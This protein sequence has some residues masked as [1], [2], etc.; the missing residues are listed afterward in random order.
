[1]QRFPRATQKFL[2][3]M[4]KYVWAATLFSGFSANDT[5]HGAYEDVQLLV[6]CSLRFEQLLI[7]RIVTLAHLP[8]VGI[9][10]IA[11]FSDGVQAGARHD[12][13]AAGCLVQLVDIIFDSGESFFWSHRILSG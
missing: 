4:Q 6:G 7:I 13:Q 1:M 2:R 5:V 10:V 3:G 12:D 8:M 11:H 9:V